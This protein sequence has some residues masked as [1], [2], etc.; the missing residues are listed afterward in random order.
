MH[1]WLPRNDMHIPTIEEVAE[2]LALAPAPQPW[3]HEAPCRHLI[4]QALCRAGWKWW[5]AD[6]RA[7]VLV[8]RAR[9]KLNIRAPVGGDSDHDLSSWVELRACVICDRGFVPTKS[10]HECC[11]HACR[12]RK[13]QIAHQPVGLRRCQRCRDPFDAQRQNQ[14]YCSDRCRVATQNARAWRRRKLDQI[15]QCQQCGGTIAHTLRSDSRFCSPECLRQDEF[16]KRRERRRAA[17][18]AADRAAPRHCAHCATPLPI[19]AFLST[20]Y[21]GNPCVQAAYHARKQNGHGTNGHAAHAPATNSSAAEPRPNG[22]GGPN[23][24]TRDPGA[25]GDHRGREPDLAAATGPAGG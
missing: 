7:F 10:D 25:G 12:Q 16:R 18:E 2:V 6:R 11:S 1:L 23:D 22:S 4:R 13:Y 19:G 14:R 5:A 8:A 21:C 20:K 24:V 17:R 9:I 15:T 3:K